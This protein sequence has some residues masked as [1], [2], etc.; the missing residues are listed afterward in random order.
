MAVPP[1]A[2]G[3]SGP[4]GPSDDAFLEGQRRIDDRPPFWSWGAIYGL[5]LGALAVQVLVY[6]V[7]T[8]VLR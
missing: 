3:G 2:D 5:V 8:R 1:N 7:L 6:A 4:D